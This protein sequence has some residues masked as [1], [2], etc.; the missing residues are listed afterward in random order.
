[1]GKGIK[2]TLTSAGLPLSLPS[3]FVAVPFSPEKAFIF[4]SV[5]GVYLLEDMK[6]ASHRLVSS[7]TRAL[8]QFLFSYN[9][10]LVY[11]IYHSICLGKTGLHL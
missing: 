3:T 7:S 5:F 8:T 11:Y 2:R 9:E 4:S 1:M 10:N 6:A